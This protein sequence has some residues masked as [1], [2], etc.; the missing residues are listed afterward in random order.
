MSW[1]VKA[2][3][4]LTPRIWFTK[5]SGEEEEDTKN[6]QKVVVKSMD[7]NPKV[8]DGCWPELMEFCKAHIIEC[9]AFLLFLLFG[10]FCIL[11]A[12]GYLGPNELKVRYS[13]YEQI[14]NEHCQFVENRNLHGSEG[15]SDH[16]NAT[17]IS[18]LTVVRHGDRYGLIAEKKCQRLSNQETIEFDEYLERIKDQN[19]RNLL[20]V[21]KGLEEKELAPSKKECSPSGLT[22]RGAIQ[23]F[24]MG[25]FL[26]NQYKAT[27]LFNSSSGAINISLTFSNLQRTYDSGVALISGFL[28]QHQTIFMI[29]VELKEGSIYYG[30][31]DSGCECN[32]TMAVNLMARKERQ[33]L[34]RLEAHER[35]Q[36]VAQKLLAEVNYTSLNID[37]ADI[38]D[39]L[40]VR[41][42]CPRKPFPCNEDYCASYLFFGDILEYF[43]KQSE[44]LFDLDMGVERQYR[45]ISAYPILRY[46]GLMAQNQIKEIQL[47]S[48]HDTIIGSLLRILT[49]SGK[50]NDWQLFAA[51]VVFE[52]YETPEKSRF[53]RVLH[54]GVDIT[55]S[56]HFC[57]RLDHG[58]C[59]V[60]DL[61]QFLQERIF[62]MAGFKSFQ[63]ICKDSK[64]DFHF[65]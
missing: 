28:D 56:I 25:K 41:Y 36:Q 3:G 5:K 26:Y 6:V 43:S 47:F 12:F 54:D 18:L 37:P 42:G 30:C 1:A 38:I 32:A 20:K 8:E 40:V 53:L 2:R 16:P 39:N 64:N 9:S 58:L 23:E 49:D 15:Q 52:I 60:A 50:Y 22:P 51:R 65:V 55:S 33:G 29:P 62:E 17:L 46:V 59:P 14:V 61:Q 45:V 48:S 11:N 57:T 7:P 34:F 19:L 21:P 24:A 4:A 31:T 27:S 44:K 35:V 63:D 10:F 13:H